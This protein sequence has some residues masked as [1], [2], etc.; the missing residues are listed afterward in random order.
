MPQ[1]PPPAG[2]DALP[3]ADRL[4]LH[5]LLARY[6]HLL[7]ERDYD[8]LGEIFAAEIR[9]DATDFGQPVWEGLAALI[10]GMRE[11]DRHPVAH[12]STNVVLGPRR[13]DGSV[14]VLSKGPGVGRRGRVGS[15]TYDDVAVPTPDGWRLASRTVTLRRPV[16][17]AGVEGRDG[18]GSLASRVAQLEARAAIGQ[19]PI[20][21]ALAV[22]GRDV[23][24]WVRLFTPDIAL[25][26]HGS[27]RA[28]L[29][30]LIE[31]QLRWFYRSVHQVV[32]HEV[33]LL[34]DSTARGRVYCRAEHEVGKRWIVMA[35]CY[36]DEYRRVDGEWLFSRRRELHWYSAD[37]DRPPQQDGFDGWTAAGD[38]PLP[39]AF[40]TWREFWAGTD[41]SDLTE[42]P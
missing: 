37:V 11:H 42:N 3:V 16:P 22:D 36:Q 9:Y 8:R 14:R 40:P 1:V 20:R 26:R 2:R 39:G 24:A 23:D 6:G 10:A 31:P 30:E 4:E 18:D 29:R 21:Y 25:G 32:G 38:P 5:E 33:E 34:D 28:A 7:D 13:P 27:G 19:L 17:G 41:T 12:H 15:A 35:I